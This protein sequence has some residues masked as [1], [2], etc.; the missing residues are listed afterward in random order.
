MEVLQTY[1][2]CQS[3]CFVLCSGVWSE[4]VLHGVWALLFSN[5]SRVPR[6]PSLLLRPTLRWAEDGGGV[7]SWVL[8]GGPQPAVLAA[9]ERGGVVVHFA[10][11]PRV[12]PKL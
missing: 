5:C 2:D 3:S 10:L 1:Q 7:R 9:V 11:P 6:Y 8:I 12:S 4:L